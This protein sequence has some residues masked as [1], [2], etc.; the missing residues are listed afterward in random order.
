MTAFVFDDE[1]LHK[2]MSGHEVEILAGVGIEWASGSKQ[3]IEC[4]YPD[5]DDENPSWRWDEKEA[6]AFC[7][8]SKGVKIIGVV[9]KKE[10]LDYPSAKLRIAEI[11]RRDDLIAT[12]GKHDV[13]WH[14]NPPAGTRDD[15]L[16]KAYLAYRLGVAPE[17]VL[18]PTT[19]MAGWRA[20]SYYEGGR[21]NRI[22]DYPC[23]VF[24]IVNPAGH[25]HGTRV[26]VADHGRGKAELPP[27]KNGAR[28]DVKKALPKEGVDLP[29]HSVLWG[30]PTKAHTII[31]GEG[32]E[33]CQALAQAHEADIR[34]GTV[35]VAAA[36]SESWMRSW[37]PWPATERVI[38]VADRDEGED[39]DDK[40]Y[41]IGQDAAETLAKKLV[42]AGK[43]VALAVPG[44]PGTDC[45]ALDVWVANG[46]SAVQALV[47]GAMPA[48]ECRS[49]EP[50]SGD[51]SEP[52]ARDASEPPAG[53]ARGLV[54]PHG[55]S[56]NDR[57]LWY[58]PA[59]RADGTD[60]DAVWVCAPV[61]IVARTSDDAHN[62][63]GLLLRWSNIDGAEHTWPM[64]LR[65]VHAEGNVIAAEL[66]DAGLRC[67]TSRAAHEYLKHFLGAVRVNRRV[68]CVDRAGWHGSAYV[69]PNGAVF[70][71]DELEMQSE[72]AVSV[73][74]YAAHCTLVEWKQQ[75]ARYAI[76]N[77]RLTLSVSAAF[78]PP[79]LE[80][81]NAPSGGLHF[82]GQSQIGKTTLQ[83]CAAS[84][85]GPAE[86]GM[87]VRSW[88]ATS[89]GLEGTAAERCDGLLPL[90]ETN[91]VEPHDV[92]A[93]VYMLANQQGKVR[94][95][96]SGVAIPPV[97]WRLLFISSGE[98]TIAATL[99]EVR[100]RLPAGAE[101]RLLNVPADAGAGMGVWQHLHGLPNGAALT[102]H[103]RAATV[104]TA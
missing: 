71:A 13:R 18:M 11:L 59:T 98:K 50:P 39:P 36:I 85:W 62:S 15:Q 37:Q 22:G 1:A 67:G 97:M 53:D 29:G 68:R 84:V 17:A 66:Q 57:G 47:A 82:Y 25:S 93:V 102:D 74:T 54:L 56:L 100:K 99:A 63:H 60:P 45:D 14:L 61:R 70:G 38:I 86:L 88:R 6:R 49:A 80:I 7:T 12:T 77:D 21:K 81:V 2:A 16:P 35:A 34:T 104:N 52:P 46:A 96:R 20:L 69:L 78:A 65:L 58:Q 19:R 51:A 79:L 30:D 44:E 55:F 83:Q 32:V 73:E 94:A 31:V 9:M 64:P 28:R 27:R 76:G 26:Y 89:N 5:H 103:L 40:R 48:S 8:C 33:T 23:V 90:D 10:G 101:V 95:N 87:Q 72:H 3:H 4:P 24:E 43:R 75:V 42:A 91:Q 92:I 41:G